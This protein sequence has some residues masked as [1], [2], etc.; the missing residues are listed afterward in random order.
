MKDLTKGSI[1]KGILLFALPLL[2]ANF[3]Q[4]FYTVIDG[5]IVGKHIGA[6]ALGAIGATWAI[7]NLIIGAGQGVT[8]GMSMLI[9]R[10][11]GAKNFK[12][13]SQSFSL[14][15]Y[16]TLVISLVLTVL[17]VVFVGPLLHLIQTP[18]SLFEMSR[19]FMLTIFIGM[20]FPNLYNYLSASTRAM[21]NS[22]ISLIA[23]IVSNVFNII[24]SSLLVM[25]FNMGVLGAGI[26]TASAQAVSVLYLVI[27]VKRKQP[28]FKF[29]F[30]PF[31][32]EDLREHLRMGLPMGLQSSII[33]IGS[34]IQQVAVNTMGTTAI[35]A[36]T[37]GQRYDGFAGMVTN[38]LGIAM[39]TFAAQNLGAKTYS[40]I[41]KGI[42]DILM[43]AIG[44]SLLFGAVLMLFN[45]LFT[46]FFMNE[47][48]DPA[49]FSTTFLY[50]LA[51]G[52]VYWLLG[53]LF[54]TRYTLQGLG[55]VKAPTLAG[56]AE[57][58]FR[59]IFAIIGV[60]THNEFIVFASEGVAWIGSTGVLIPSIR[61]TFRE[62]KEKSA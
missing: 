27:Y 51:N 41:S 36:V 60:L 13:L 2:L 37:I 6:T 59:T 39:A 45:R 11:Y 47:S 24:F 52:S 26:A 25:V 56:T 14:G 15:F 54:V 9:S 62:L 10:Y 23:L 38:S 61:K 20:V 1:V 17:G 33:S 58:V 29:K 4:M 5:V 42:K 55:N 34:I 12:A 30:I 44:Y 46:G 50:Y 57:L 3:F 22:R 43:I 32:R 53:I 16:A 49:I 35:I 48:S 28:Y 18:D 40:R 8:V 31:S 21:G 19:T 7:S